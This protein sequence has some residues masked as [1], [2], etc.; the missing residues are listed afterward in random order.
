M[1][2]YLYLK[3]GRYFMEK[4]YELWSD[5]STALEFQSAL[6]KQYNCKIMLVEVI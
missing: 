5:R 3:Y 2:H 6:S 4:V 1:K